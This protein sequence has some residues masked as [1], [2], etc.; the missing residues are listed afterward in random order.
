MSDT[1]KQHLVSAFNTFLT[2]ALITIGAQLANGIPIEW[3]MT[4][5]AGVVFAAARAGIKAVTSMAFDK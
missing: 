5:W 2:A 4:F 3:T 1:L